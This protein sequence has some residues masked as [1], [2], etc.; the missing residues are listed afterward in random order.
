[1]TFQ[2][3]LNER[4]VYKI[5]CYVCGKSPDYTDVDDGFYCTKCLRKDYD[6]Q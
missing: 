2:E 6:D 3:W 1:M 4:E 5:T